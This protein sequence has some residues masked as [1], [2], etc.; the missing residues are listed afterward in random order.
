MSVVATAIPMWTAVFGVYAY[1]SRATNN[2]I[3]GAST[4]RKLGGGLYTEQPDLKS[5]RDMKTVM[6]DC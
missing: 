2:T 6:H 4:R 3:A 1:N 5:D